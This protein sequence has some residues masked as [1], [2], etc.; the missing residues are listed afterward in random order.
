LKFERIVAFSSLICP[1]LV[2]R[3]SKRQMSRK[4]FQVPHALDSVLDPLICLPAVSNLTVCPPNWVQKQIARSRRPINISRNYQ[5]FALDFEIIN[6]RFG[7]GL[8]PLSIPGDGGRSRHR[9]PE[10]KLLNRFETLIACRFS[11]EENNSQ[12]IDLVKSMRLLILSWQNRDHLA[13]RWD[14]C[15]R[16]ACISVHICR[17][18]KCMIF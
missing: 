9:N 12:I 6:C 7:F 11:S 17:S 15:S 8:V 3:T 13:E 14:K 16:C 18:F 10:L 1:G 5:K 4:H 2:M